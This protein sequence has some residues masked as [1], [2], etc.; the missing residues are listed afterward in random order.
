MKAGGAPNDVRPAA[1]Q[2]GN[3]GY[4]ACSVG[5]VGGLGDLAMRS[6]PTPPKEPQDRPLFAI[7]QA[8]NTSAISAACSAW[9]PG[10]VL[11]CLDRETEPSLPALPW[12]LQA[13]VTPLYSVTPVTS[14][15]KSPRVAA[16]ATAAPT[17]DGRLP[18]RAHTGSE[19]GRPRH[20]AVSADSQE[21]RGFQ[22]AGR[23]AHSYDAVCIV[24][25]TWCN[26]GVH[27]PDPPGLIHDDPRLLPPWR[28]SSF[29]CGA[30]L[31]LPP[32]SRRDRPGH[33]PT[34]ST[35]AHGLT[36]GASPA[37]STVSQ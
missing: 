31:R 8:R 19:S 20:V 30:R 28:G 22:P 37:R 15:V 21:K 3:R 5:C 18:N 11:G 24:G 17:P 1:R 33:F 9:V 25:R 12:P 36:G 34:F 23:L 26:P 35:G 6:G 13:S 32:V 7:T 29:I 27:Q 16:N 4:Q 10:T 14:R 2:H